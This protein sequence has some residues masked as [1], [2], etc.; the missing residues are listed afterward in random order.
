MNGRS[1]GSFTFFK[2]NGLRKKVFVSN[3]LNKSAPPPRPSRFS[4]KGRRRSCHSSWP[5]ETRV[6]PHSNCSLTRFFASDS[7]ASSSDSRLVLSR[8][9]SRVVFTVSS[10][11]G[12]IPASVVSTASVIFRKYSHPNDF[13]LFQKTS[14][15]V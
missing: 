10:E 14:S 7:N 8:S 3:H 1:F 2:T 13:F 5:S 4:E 12:W 11:R 6:N 15:N 9:K